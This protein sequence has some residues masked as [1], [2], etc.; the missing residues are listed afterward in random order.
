MILVCQDEISTLPAGT[1]FALRLPVEIEF[2]PG[3]V[4]QF[5][6]WHLFRFVCIF[7]EFLFTEAVQCFLK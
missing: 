3:K 5:S 6:T 1:D 7:F 4:G 2:R